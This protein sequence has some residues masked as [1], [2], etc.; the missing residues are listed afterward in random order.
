M[1]EKSRKN[2][3]IDNRS[4]DLSIT[5]IRQPNI[6]HPNQGDYQHI[7]SIY[8]VFTQL[9]NDKCD[10]C[11]NLSGP[12]GSRIS[13]EDCLA[14]IENLPEKVDRLILSGGE[15]LAEKKKLYLI[16]DELKEKYGNET[17]LMLQTNGDLLTGEILDVLIEKGI[18]RF[19]IASID[20]YHKTAGGRLME[21]AELFDSRE[22]NGDEKD[23]L[24]KKENYLHSFPLSWGY[25]GAS[26]DMW[27]GGNWA[28]GRA[29]KKGIWKQD[30]DH[31]F[32]AIL[33][34]AIGFLNGG[35]DIPQ[36][37]SIQLWK[38]NPCC[39]GT[40]DPL[41]DARKEKVSEVLERISE[42][43]VF[44]KL[45]KGDPYRMGESIGISE[46]HARKRCGDLKNVCLW[47]D[48]FFTKHYDIKKQQAK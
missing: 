5:Q 23:P 37:I 2:Q 26:E 36:E 14:I 29:L 31:N 10:H 15:P 33:S 32:C 42:N 43:P 6:Q 12:Q 8:W 46:K 3:D 19:D 11:Y 38:I 4:Q 47:C 16:L 18:T 34:G 17:Q 48:E 21:L 44:Q 24:V 27:L 41:G 35:K 1:K 20:R 7:E 22:V 30:P 45:D 25:W 39:P 28:R 9:C 40:K 13:E